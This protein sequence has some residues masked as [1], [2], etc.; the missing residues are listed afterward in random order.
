M[1][2]KSLLALVLSFCGVVCATA[3]DYRVF[4]YVRDKHGVHGPVTA[5]PKKPY[6]GSIQA[7]SV[8]EARRM[9]LKDDPDAV[10]I[11]IHQLD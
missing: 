9:I 6:A 4:Y 8:A 1:T 3:H 2:K 10:Q 7:G 5:D 11:E